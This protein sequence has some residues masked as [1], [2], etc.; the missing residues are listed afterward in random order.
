MANTCQTCRSVHRR[1]IEEDLLN[2][3]PIRALSEKYRVGRMSILRH[4]Q[5]GHIGRAVLEAARLRERVM[6]GELLD[7]LLAL[8]AEGLAILGEAKTLPESEGPKVRLG[9]ALNA[10]GRVSDLLQ[11]EQRLVEAAKKAEFNVQV[12]IVNDPC[13]PAVLSILTEAL[14]PHAL[15]FRQVVEGL[16][17]LN[18]LPTTGGKRNG[19]AS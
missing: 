16:R 1:A 6:G 17:G 2:N 7:K 5:R 15:A 9:L 10:I 3:V 18:L 8:Q 13:W 19:Q 11:T 14:R 12:A 4:Q